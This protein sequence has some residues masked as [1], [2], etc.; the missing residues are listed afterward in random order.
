MEQKKKTIAII[1]FNTPELTEALVKSI[2]KWCAENYVIV[3]LDN[4]DA[5]PFTKKIRGVTVIDNTKQQLVNFDEELGK[6]PDK[7]F[8]LAYKGNFASVKHMMSVQYLMD[9]VLTDGFILMD[10]DILLKKDIGFLWDEKYA[11]SGRIVWYKGR[12]AEA[13]RLLPYCCYL[14]VPMLRKAGIRFYTPERC[15]GLQPGGTANPNNLY[16]TGA[17]LLE[18][19][20]KSKPKVW[21]RNWQYLESDFVHYADASYSR[22]N[23]EEHL[24]W[25]EQNRELWWQPEN[26]DVKIFI[27]THTDF[28]PIVHDEHYET[29]DSRTG[30]DFYTAKGREKKKAAKVP[31]PFYSELLHMYRI[32]QQNDLPKYIGFVQYRKYFDFLN[33]LPDIPSVIAEHG[34]ISP[35]PVS[36]GLPMR[37]QWASWGNVED[38]DLATEIVNEK[39]PELA[40]TWNEN[41]TKDTMHPGSLH[42]METEEWKEMVAVAWDVANEW[43]KRIGGDIDKRI[44]AN[45]EKY[46]IGEHPIMDQPNERRVGGNICERIVS[47]WADWKHPN[48]ALYP[49]VVT[50]EKVAPNFDR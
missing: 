41:L 4:S 21:C 35:T 5:R 16:D 49:L 32:S 23:V 6:Y 25:I 28:E 7:C 45:P 11:A 14:N 38:L 30:G 8:D 22:N 50:A 37:E 24:K 26:K 1:H 29:I 40:K 39:Y 19:I 27:C 9:E 17:S 43:L 46:H 47:A 13:D 12:R 44:E 20:I 2:R 18:D 10:S 48:V 3:I 42:I 36:I 33:R 34:M 31:G 15:W